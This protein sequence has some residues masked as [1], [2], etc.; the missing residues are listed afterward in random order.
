MNFIESN[1]EIAGVDKIIANKIM[2]SSEEIITNIINYAYPNAVGSLKIKFIYKPG[3]ITIT[4]IDEGAPF[5]PLEK[6]GVDITL[7][8]EN[9][10]AGG[11]GILM[12]KN[13]MDEMKYEFKKGKNHLS[14]I[15]FIS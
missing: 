14:L 12:A 9:R 13:L 2:T 15:K 11:L 4:F 5:N 3:K 1:L 8:L 7:P 6:P 10:E